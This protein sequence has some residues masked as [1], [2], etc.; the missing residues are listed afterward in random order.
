MA[1]GS[2]TKYTVLG[3]LTLGPKSGYDIKRFIGSSIGNFWRESYGQIY[4]TLKSLAAGGLVSRQVQD[5]EGRPDRYVY[6]LTREGREELRKWLVEPAE[7]EIPRHE[8]L[9]KLFFGTEISPDATLLHVTRYKR[10]A[11][12]SLT[13]LKEVDRTLRKGRRDSPGLPY[14]LLTVRQGILVEE[15]LLQWCEEAKKELLRLKAR[16]RTKKRDT[17]RRPLS[18]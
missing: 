11:E 4:P 17:R 10:D 18:M 3:T 6:Q 7:P 5:Q 13:M 16:L 8:L 9:L 2:R 14:W 12:E 15:A 1:R